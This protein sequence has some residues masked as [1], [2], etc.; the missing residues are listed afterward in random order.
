MNLGGG[1]FG[2]INWC[3]VE[4]NLFVLI[5]MLNGVV[6]LLLNVVVICVLLFWSVVMVMFSLIVVFKLCIF[7]DKI[8]CSFGC[9][10]LLV[11][12]VF[13]LSNCGNWIE[14][15]GVLV[16]LCS[17]IW[18]WGVFFMVRVLF[19]FRWF[20]VWNVNGE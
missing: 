10:I 7:C 1:V 4:N 3:V 13:G 14:L 19:M 12:F 8:V 11:V 18:L 17:V 5:V 16:R 6:D 15:S 9:I 2:K 20:R